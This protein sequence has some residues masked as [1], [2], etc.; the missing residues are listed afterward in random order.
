MVKTN[1]II[2]VVHLV[3]LP[4]G[5]ELYKNFINSYIKFSVGYE[6]ELI[7][8]FNGV[9]NENELHS[10]FKY[11]EI[12]KIKYKYY[13]FK[14]GQDI[15]AYLWVSGK[16]AEYTHLLFLNSFSKILHNDWL[17]YYVNAIELPGVGLVG[18]TGSW[19]SHYSNVFKEHKIGYEFKKTLLYNFR[20]YKLFLKAF[21]YWRFLFA[22]FPSPHIRTTG[23]MIKRDLFLQ[24]EREKIISKFDAYLFESGRNG[25]SNQL[26]K[27]GY[28]ILVVNKFGETYV[29][30]SWPES[31]TFWIEE[32]QNLLIEDNQTKLYC[33]ANLYERKRLKELAW[34]TL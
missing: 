21:F 11:A 24:L 31:N 30:N 26:I 10:Y 29:P 12:S 28:Q 25:I 20:K 5:I 9:N 18:A 3:W 1:N 13:C 7:F 16:I 4:Y 17:Q 19:Q 14:N 34:G 6:H 8:L 22:P 32:Q 15:Q 2:G 33:K 27:K 23:F